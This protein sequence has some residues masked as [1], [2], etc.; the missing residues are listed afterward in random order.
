[1]HAPTTTKPLQ[2]VQRGTTEA[3]EENDDTI[4]GCRKKRA[5][6]YMKLHAG[7]VLSDDDTVAVRDEQDEA[8]VPTQT[9]TTK[10]TIQTSFGTV[11]VTHV[12]PEKARMTVITMHDFCMNHVL[13]F[14]SLWQVSKSKFPFKDMEVSGFIHASCVA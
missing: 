4:E 11:S 8:V 2:G 12:K 10:R 13:A 1:M 7:R 9:T 6:E 14:N 5:N 3:T